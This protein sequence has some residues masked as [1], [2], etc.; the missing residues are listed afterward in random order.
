MVTDWMAAR[1]SSPVMAG[2]RSVRRQWLK[3][4][5]EVGQFGDAG[6]VEE[7][8]VV[9]DALGGG[10]L[11]AIGGEV[12]AAGAGRRGSALSAGQRV[13]AARKRSRARTS[14]PEA[15]ASL[16]AVARLL[17]EPNCR[18]MAW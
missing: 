18:A 11:G 15:H 4:V 10:A 8:V 3:A 14:S 9:C 5:A 2:E 1:E 16:A 6:V 13:K 17:R 12:V 7:V